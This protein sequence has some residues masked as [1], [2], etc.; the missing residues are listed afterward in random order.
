[1]HYFLQQMLWVV[2]SQVVDKSICQ[3]QALDEA[4]FLGSWET[5]VPDG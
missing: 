4:L 2:A 5:H 3:I 1:M